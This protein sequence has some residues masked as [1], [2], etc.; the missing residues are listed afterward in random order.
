M[1]L[2]VYA[3][4]TRLAPAV[5]HMVADFIGATKAKKI[6]SASYF[7]VDTSHYTSYL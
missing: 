6:A 4:T 7:N 1:L 3:K 2:V 5:F